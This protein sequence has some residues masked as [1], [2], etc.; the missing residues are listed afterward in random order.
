MVGKNAGDGKISA[1]SCPQKFCPTNS[2]CQFSSLKI[3]FI[4][5]ESEIFCLC[6][7]SLKKV[8]L[9]DTCS[10]KKTLLKLH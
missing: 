7:Q 1:F 3:E 2:T 9:N 6:H 5:Q 4:D 8:S 10:G